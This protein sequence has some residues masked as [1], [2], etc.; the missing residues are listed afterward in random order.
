MTLIWIE[1]IL[2][3]RNVPISTE[4]AILVRRALD[5]D[6]YVSITGEKAR[7]YKIAEGDNVL[8]GLR[9]K[10][11]V[12]GQIISQRLLRIADTF[13]YPYLNATTVSYSG[14]LPV[15]LFS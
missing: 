1:I 3:D 9:G 6:K 14:Q 15:I 5:E 12:K 11:K 2:E 8:R 10:N 4:T 7:K 13:E